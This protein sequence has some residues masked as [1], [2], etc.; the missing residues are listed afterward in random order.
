MARKNI[1]FSTAVS[2]HGDVHT[3][4]LPSYLMAG[5]L[6]YVTFNEAEMEFY[7]D[8]ELKRIEGVDSAITMFLREIFKFNIKPTKYDVVISFVDEGFSE[9]EVVQSVGEVFKHKEGIYISAMEKKTGD[10]GVPEI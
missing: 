8:G 10:G 1:S 3:I 6:D 4:E 2:K 5:L 9:S 7:P